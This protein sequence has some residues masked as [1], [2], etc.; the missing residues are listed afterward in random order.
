MSGSPGTSGVMCCPSP[1]EVAVRKVADSR[2]VPWTW[3]KLFAEE[4]EV[5]R[6]PDR[7]TRT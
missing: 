2:S 7:G 5:R 4:D 6:G 3:L 1:A